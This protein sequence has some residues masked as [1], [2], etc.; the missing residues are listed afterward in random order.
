MKNTTTK[1]RRPNTHTGNLKAF[2][3][4]GSAIATIAGT[5]LLPLQDG[6]TAEAPA[7]TSDPVTVVV[8]V[9]EASSID[10]PPG[11]RRTQVELKPIPQVV[12]PEIQPVARTRSS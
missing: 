6:G 10:L 5:Q 3:L 8:P 11:E 4:A 12:E 1:R 7:P 9:G 2:L